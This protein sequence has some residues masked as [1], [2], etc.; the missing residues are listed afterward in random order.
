MSNFACTMAAADTTIDKEDLPQW[1][2]LELSVA[3]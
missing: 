3:Q 2:E 1:T